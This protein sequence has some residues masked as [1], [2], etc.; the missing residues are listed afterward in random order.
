LIRDGA[1]KRTEHLGM[2]ELDQD[3]DASG[4]SALGSDKL[5]ETVRR[6][7]PRVRT[8]KTVG[9]E[10]TA[11]ERAA[12]RLFALVDDCLSRILRLMPGSE[13][14]EASQL[15]FF[16][17]VEVSSVDCLAFGYLSLM[18]EAPV[19]RSFLKDWL[20]QKKP[21]L[22]AFVDRI[23]KACLDTPGELPW[24]SP[25]KLGIA[26]FTGRILDSTIRHMPAIGDIYDHETRRRAERRAIGLKGLDTRT[27]GLTLG[28]LAVGLSAGYGVFVYRSLQPFGARLQIWRK[29]AQGFGRFGEAGAL[30][31]LAMPVA[32]AAGNGTPIG[33]GGAQVG[34]RFAD[35]DTDELLVAVEQQRAAA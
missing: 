25:P 17:G 18:R 21:Q 4:G 29:A 32:A 35:A 9:E 11:E 30:L 13:K 1:L 8:Q 24:T 23:Q 20:V 2:G 14:E 22:S 31:G 26:H 12:I 7:L 27:W 33:G 15:G 6:H 5:P 34:G 10:M 28:V 3:F 19:P 16:E